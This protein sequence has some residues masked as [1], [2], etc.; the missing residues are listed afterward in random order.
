MDVEVKPHRGIDVATKKEVDCGVYQIR[1]DGDLAGFIGYH[2]GARPMMLERRS[3]L[4]LREI[5]RK[6]RVALMPQ[7]VGSIAQIQERPQEPKPVDPREI[8][9]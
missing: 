4:E 7:H 6:V 5:E 1:I 8:Y 3:P 2:E 9:E